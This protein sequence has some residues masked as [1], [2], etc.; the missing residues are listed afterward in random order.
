MKRYAAVILII[1]LVST[2][3]VYAAGLGEFSSYLYGSYFS[4]Q[5]YDDN[6]SRIVRESG[7]IFGAGSIATFDLY[8]Q[9]LLLTGK[10]EI[11]G[12]VVNYAGQTQSDFSA[13]D[14]RPVDS[15]TTYFGGKVEADMGW[16]FSQTGGDIEPFIG[17]GYRVWLRDIQ[18]S[19]STTKAGTSFSVSGATEYW[20]TVYARLGLRAKTRIND[21]TTLFLEAG[22]LYPLYTRN[23]ALDTIAGDVT[24]KPRSDWSTFAELGIRYRSF[25]PAVFYEGIR[26]RRSDDVYQAG[27]QIWQPRSESDTVGI[28]LGYFFH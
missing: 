2:S 6:G 16:R 23:E 3:Q 8:Q 5:E 24:L 11:F 13:F 21:S 18:N 12:S 28:S 15:D 20:S 22:A 7:P 10:A 27:Y 1:L 14:N 9:S 19:T 26:F 25:R 17:A 4:W